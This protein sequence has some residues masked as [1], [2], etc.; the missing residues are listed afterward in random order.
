M[1]DN[2]IRWQHRRRGAEGRGKETPPHVARQAAVAPKALASMGGRMIQLN[3]TEFNLLGFNSIGAYGVEFRP[4]KLHSLEFS[5]TQLNSI[6]PNPT[7][8]N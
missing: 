6:E 2:L 5:W 1:K 3:P 7:E 4:S 8:F